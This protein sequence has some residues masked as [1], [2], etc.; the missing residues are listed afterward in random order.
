MTDLRYPIGK[1]EWTVPATDAD[2][3]KGRARYMANLSELPAKMRAAV[4]GLNEQQLK[5]PYRPEGWTVRQL[6]HHLPDSHLNAYIRFKLA[7][8]EDQPQIKTYDEA[9]WARLPD[10][11]VTPIET[12]LQLLAALQ[13]RWVDTLHCMKV[14]DFGRTLFHPE[15]GVLTLDQ[16]LALY[17]WHSLHH[18]AHI[19]AL[20]ERL[21]WNRRAAAT[22]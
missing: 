16:M 4:G 17:S 11:D 14:S 3:A 18:T 13:A 22:H 7:L 19:T 1:F 6:V 5:T 10:N 15:R 9:D 2:A 12:S 8:T 21:G 20:R